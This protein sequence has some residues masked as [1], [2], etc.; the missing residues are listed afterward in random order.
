VIIEGIA[1][2]E[3][4]AMDAL[5]NWIGYRVGDM[6]V[7]QDFSNDPIIVKDMRGGAPSVGR[8]SGGCDLGLGW[9]AAVAC[10][11]AYLKKSSAA[12]SRKS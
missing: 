3:S 5:V 4:A 2:S 6:A 8:A 1:P 7:I 9:A 10:L 12:G 11:L